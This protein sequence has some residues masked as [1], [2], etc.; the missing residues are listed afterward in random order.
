MTEL[1]P[2]IDGLFIDSD[3][4]SIADLSEGLFTELALIGYSL[5]HEEVKQAL[6]SD[7]RFLAGWEETDRQYKGQAA[8]INDAHVIT[9]AEWALIDPVIRAHCDWIQANR[10]EGTAS[11]GGER[12]GLSVSEAL[13][14]YR[15]AK[16]NLKRESFV[17]PPFTIQF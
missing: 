3:A 9:L 11:L 7:Y 10:V 14:I 16:D 8:T 6:I 12:F 13:T 2:T 15:D 5:D 17:E 4:A 1:S